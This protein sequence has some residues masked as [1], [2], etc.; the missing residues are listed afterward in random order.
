MGFKL[1]VLWTDAALWLLV[2][3]LVA[4][5]VHVR[6]DANLRAT[7]Q[8]VMRDHAAVSAGVVLLLLR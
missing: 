5:I 1:V 2:A 8:K 3:A 4:Y 6:R 7:W